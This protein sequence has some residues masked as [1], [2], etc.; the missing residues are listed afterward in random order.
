M[1]ILWFQ[2]AYYL[3]AACWSLFHIRSFMRLTGKKTDTWLVKTVA[4]L[5]VAISLCLLSAA[6]RNE[7]NTSILVLAFS[8]SFALTLVHCYYVWTKK[9]SNIYLA[10]AFIEVFLI[11]YW[12]LYFRNG[13]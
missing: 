2:A 12:V 6:L 8:S 3:L 7:I 1:A 5:L 13:L 4:M 11:I 10:D 9:I